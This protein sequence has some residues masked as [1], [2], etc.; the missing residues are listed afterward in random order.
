MAVILIIRGVQVF[1]RDNIYRRCAP[2]DGE[3]RPNDLYYESTVAVGIF[4][5]VS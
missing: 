4:L 3:Q 5:R 1:P 2:Y